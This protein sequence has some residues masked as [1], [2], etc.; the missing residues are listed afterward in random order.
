MPS[1]FSRTSLN[2][3]HAD[4]P[5][6]PQEPLGRGPDGRGDRPAVSRAVQTHGRRHGGGRDAGLN[7]ALWS[8]KSLR[9]A[10]HRGEPDP[11]IVQI[12]GGDPAQ[13]AEAARLSVQQGAQI[14]DI[15]MGC[16]AKRCAMSPPARRYCA[17]KRWWRASCKAV[18][19]AVDV[20]VTLK[21]RTG[22]SRAHNTALRVAKLAEDCGIAALALH[23]RSRE[24]M[25][26]GQAEYDTIRAVKAA[27]G[28]PVLANGDIDSPQ[29]PAMCLITPAPTA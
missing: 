24:D 20:P 13:M 25:Y 1:L 14:I 21:T 27:V 23:G 12:A 28:I 8:T 18:V 5:V 26:H 7:T 19:A 3:Q 16:P 11:I 15:N 9:R 29:K 2:F 10:D 17:T 22:W 6:H 4:W